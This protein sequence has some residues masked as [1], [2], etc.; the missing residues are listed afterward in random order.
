MGAKKIARHDLLARRVAVADSAR[1][2]D[3][4]DTLGLLVLPMQYAVN[5]R[6]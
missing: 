6:G 4:V 3:S 2:G 5:R 1:A